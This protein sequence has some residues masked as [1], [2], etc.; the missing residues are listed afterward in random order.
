MDTLD[1][2]TYQQVAPK[3]HHLRELGLSDR[4]IARRLGVTDKTVA[5]ALRWLQEATGKGRP[6]LTQPPCE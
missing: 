1:P 5:K 3:A 2:P 6:P 4:T